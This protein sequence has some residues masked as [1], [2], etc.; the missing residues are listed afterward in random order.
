MHDDDAIMAFGTHVF[1]ASQV[2]LQEPIG[3]CHLLLVSN[4]GVWNPGFFSI[5]AVASSSNRGLYTNH[6]LLVSTSTKFGVW[7]PRFPASQLLLPAAIGVCT[8]TDLLLVRTS[9]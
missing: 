3:V 9:A 1:P 7:D 2:L 8:Q 5:T 4:R 6:L